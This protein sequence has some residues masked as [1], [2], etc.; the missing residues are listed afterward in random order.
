M[1]RRLAALL[2][3]ASLGVLVASAIHFFVLRRPAVSPEAGGVAETGAREES[4]G[5]R[6]EAELFF[7]TAEGRLA[8]ERRELA[9]V[10]D[11]AGAVAAAVAGLLAGPEAPGL[12]P[13]FPPGVEVRGALFTAEGT[14]YVDLGR[15]DGGPPPASGSEEEMLRVQ[16]L[17]HTV[18]ASVPE[19]RLVVLLWDGQQRP[20]LAGHLDTG[21]PLRPDPRLLAPAP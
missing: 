16:A 10:E 13:A 12:L 2:V 14:A 4:G 15:G 20:S 5:E 9:P 11:V 3:G 1:S 18:V 17:V 8:G 21:S 6:W 19:A 7:P